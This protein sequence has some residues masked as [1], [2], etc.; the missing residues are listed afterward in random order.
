MIIRTSATA[1]MLEMMKATAKAMEYMT[2]GIHLSRYG[3]P[4]ARVRKGENK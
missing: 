1:Q 3:Q 2:T 4:Q